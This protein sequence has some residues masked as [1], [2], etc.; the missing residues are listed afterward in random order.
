MSYRDEVLADGPLVYYKL[1]ETSG[2]TASDSSGNARNATY[3]T[4]VT[5]GQPSLLGDGSG[6][7]AAF[8]ATLTSYTR[9]AYGSWMNV[10]TITLET[11]VK[12]DAA[13]LSGEKL[14]AA[15]LGGNLGS[16]RAFL[17]D[18]YPAG[19]L[20]FLVRN[21]ST[22]SVVSGATKLQSGKQYT[23]AA[24]Y[25]G[26]TIKVY[27]NGVLDGSVNFAGSMNSPAVDLTLGMM[28]VDPSA[29]LHYAGVLDEFSMTPG[30]LSANRL[31][32][33]HQAAVASAV[34][35]PISGVWGL[36]G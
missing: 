28:D 21:A 14:I 24:T 17:W 26:A 16:A 34:L 23:V 22:E 3:G 4:G 32:A 30:A 9:C 8:A 33:R 15:R 5:L 10:P 35:P 36:V 19:Q 29:S 18:M 20:R 6:K 1:D 7:A 31:L 12:P 25:D 2:S 13:S 11:R 27:V